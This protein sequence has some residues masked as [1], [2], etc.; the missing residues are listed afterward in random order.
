MKRTVIVFRRLEILVRKRRRTLGAVRCYNDLRVLRRRS[1]RGC[2]VLPRS[3]LVGV[4]HSFPPAPPMWPSWAL[5]SLF[6]APS[7]DLITSLPGWIGKTPTKQYS[8]FIDSTHDPKYGQL[9]SHYWFAESE[10]DPANDPVLVWF[11]GGPGA[12]SLF[13]FMAELGPFMFSDESKQTKSFNETGIPSPI[14]NKYGWTKVSNLLAISAPPPV[15]FSYCDKGGV[16]GDGYS[17]GDWDDT[18]TAIANKDALKSWIK[19]F[20]EFA[21]NGMYIAGESYAGIYVPTLVQQ[22]LADTTSGLN[23]KGFAIGDGCIGHEDMPSSYHLDFH[24]EFFHGHGQFS[25]KTFRAVQAACGAPSRAHWTQSIGADGA[26]VLHVG[27]GCAAE[28]AQMSKEIGGYCMPPCPLTDSTLT[29]TR[30][31][32]NG[33][34]FESLVRIDSYNLYDE[35]WYENIISSASSP[36]RVEAAWMLHVDEAAATVTIPRPENRRHGRAAAV[37]AR[38]PSMSLPPNPPVSLGGALNDYACGGPVV[39]VE[40][41][42]LTAVKRA[43]HVPDDAYFFQCDNGAGFNYHGNTKALMPFYRHVIDDTDLRV[44]VYNGDAD[45]GL[46]SFYAQNW[47]AALGYEEK[48]GWRP[49]TLDGKIAVGGYVTRYADNFDYLTIRGAGHMVPEYQSR[50][51]LE[52][53]SRWLANEEYQRYVHGT[54]GR[55]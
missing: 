10:N 22:I 44:L 11:N 25:D 41:L 35:C 12:S 47:T 2:N 37:A 32:S 53:I 21:K 4:Q 34:S 6:A 13:G 46:N 9:H 20:P 55:K 16:S 50:A 14:Y 54:R 23:L 49:W 36:V 33:P 48:E 8:G 31:A 52:F 40:Y 18:R 27:A 19:A 1:P 28:L 51:S 38:Q 42:N 17:C 26:H 15:G 7:A 45:P 39:Q 3:A 30:H 24:I 29:P 5:V 43:L